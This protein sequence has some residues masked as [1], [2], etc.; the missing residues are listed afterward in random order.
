MGKKFKF[1]YKLAIF[2]WLELSE[3]RDVVVEV[4]LSQLVENFS[5]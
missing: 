2:C 5:E 1:M 3:T 4:A